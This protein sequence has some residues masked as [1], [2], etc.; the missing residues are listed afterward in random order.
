MASRICH[1]WRQKGGKWPTTTYLCPFEVWFKSHLFSLVWTSSFLV[2]IRKAIHWFHKV[3]H[4]LKTSSN[5]HKYLYAKNSCFFSAFES[6]LS[7][8]MVKDPYYFIIFSITNSFKTM[9]MLMKEP[10]KAHLNRHNSITNQFYPHFP[11]RS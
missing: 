1:I 4:S 3:F 8:S 10:R 5:F 7:V 6:R 9:K 2:P 11:V